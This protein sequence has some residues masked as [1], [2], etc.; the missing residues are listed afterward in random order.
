MDQEE[1]Y[2]WGELFIRDRDDRE[3][4]MS[5]RAAAMGL[6]QRATEETLVW[7][8][9]SQ[10]ECRWVFIN[11]PSDL[12]QIR[13]VY[14]SAHNTRSPCCFVVVK[15]PDAS[16]TR[17]DTIFDIFRLNPTSYLWHFHRVYTR[18]AGQSE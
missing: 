12:E 7:H 6:T 10:E 5:H 14:N 16:D 3:A 17:G 4:G 18:P 8:R 1:C 15:Q 9:G 11:D 13:A 2:A